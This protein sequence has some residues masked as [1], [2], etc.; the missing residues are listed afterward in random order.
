MLR[1]YEFYGCLFKAYNK[2]YVKLSMCVY[3]THESGF[4]G[5]RSILEEGL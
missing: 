3:N 1:K 4:F 2:Y 5:E